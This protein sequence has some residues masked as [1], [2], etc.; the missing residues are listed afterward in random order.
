MATKQKNA[1]TTVT[2]KGFAG[3]ILEGV[4][5]DKQTK[6][7][8]L[9]VEKIEDFAIECDAQIALIKSSVIPGL[10]AK[11]RKV[12]KSVGKAEKAVESR[13][14]NVLGC[15]DFKQYAGE[16]AVAKVGVESVQDEVASLE[17]EIQVAKDSLETY[18]GLLKQLNS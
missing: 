17:D 7:A 10:L 1:E 14:D 11:V 15:V 13:V 9:I 18:E 3:R 6:T 2:L 5:K 16:I 8:E 12:K 4:S